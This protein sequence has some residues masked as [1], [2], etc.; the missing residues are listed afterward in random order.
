M[1]DQMSV[2]RRLPRVLDLKYQPG[3][4]STALC[5]LVFLYAPIAV[6]VVFSFNANRSVTRWTEFWLDW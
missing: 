5:C 1:A 2:G 3:F 4:G 6:L